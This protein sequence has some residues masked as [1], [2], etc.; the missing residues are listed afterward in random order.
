MK[1]HLWTLLRIL[2][3]VLVIA[4]VASGQSNTTRSTSDAAGVKTTSTDTKKPSND[5]KKPADAEPTSQTVG[6][7]TGD[8]VTTGTLEVGYRGLRVDGDVNKFRSDL[9]YKAGPRLFDSSLLMK[10]KNGK[11]NLFETLL[12]TSTGWGADPTG[13]L[14]FNV[15]KP[16]WYRFEG[17]YRR[18]KYFRYL[19]NFVNPNWLFT[20]FPVPPN[21]N[22]GLHNYNTRTQLGDFELTILPKNELI[23]FTIGYSPERYEGPFFT[24]YHQGGNEF[25]ALVNARSQAND[26]RFGA[27]GKL[28]PIDWTFLQG[29]RRFRDDSFIDTVPVFINPNPTNTARFTTF[30]RNEPS[31]GHLN[32]TRASLHT[33]IEKRLDITGRIIYSK[34]TSDSV[35]VENFTGT[36]FN[37]RIT[38]L[39]APPNTLTFGLI[40]IGSNVE[41]PQSIGDIGV[42]YL[43]TDK[44]R[45]SNTFRVEDFEIN[46]AGLYDAAFVLTRPPASTSSSFPSGF[47]ANNVVKYRKYL[48]TLE[49]DY[50]FNR[51]YSIHLGYRY[52]TRHE[53]T[54]HTGFN[55]GSLLPAA[56]VP[57]SETETN[58]THS[59]IGGFRARPVKNW[60][61]YFDGEHGTADNVFTRIGNYDYTNIRAKSRY[62]PDRRVNFN[63]SLITRNNANPSEIAGESISDFGASIKSRTFQTSIDWMAR[64]DLT[65]NIGYNYNWVNSDATIDYYYQVPPATS[66]FHHFGHALYFMRNNFFFVDSTWRVHRRATLFTSYRINQDR[67]QGNQLSDP[68]GGTPIPGGIVVAGSLRNPA[69]TGGNLVTSYP[70]SFQS[71]EARLAIRINRHL[72]WNLGYQYF[73]YNENNFVLRSFPPASTR[74]QNYHA[75]LPYMSLR[76]YV[77]RKE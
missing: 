33:L 34:S 49:G 67:G 38:G 29:F 66:V 37:T 60:T 28:G 15:E 16:K 75:H 2:P 76:I 1:Q 77:G 53:E 32:F 62:A 54:L 35:F 63:V 13:N 47:T 44:L 21:P 40:N 56:L 3:V 70:M 68:T 7:D 57:E 71:P 18:M 27:D 55:F 17:S 48:N 45:I 72:D 46:G 52:G 74:A 73:N 41:R 50:Q 6:E 43:A 31:R 20:G 25:Q 61:L 9:N 5:T 14:R 10:A 36:N 24:T 65:F 69:V 8:Y 59:F 30:S 11:G 64:P 22:T 42:T 4:A 51:N 39:L 58:H 12:I 19:N 23:R 26:F